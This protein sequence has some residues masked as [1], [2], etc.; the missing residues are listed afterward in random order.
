MSIIRNEVIRYYQ[1]LQF[2]AMNV[3]C[4]AIWYRLNNLKSMKNTYGGVLLLTKL[5]IKLL[6]R[7]FSHFLNCT[8]GT[9]SNN[10]SHIKV[11]TIW[12]PNFWF[13]CLTL[14][15]YRFLYIVVAF[16]RYRKIKPFLFECTQIATETA[17]YRNCYL[18]RTEDQISRSN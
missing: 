14:S 18:K 3:M 12:I 15:K 13:Q 8:N 5:K 11:E 2:Y 17:S 1:N 16:H 6:R 4:C 7:C 10:V 9:K